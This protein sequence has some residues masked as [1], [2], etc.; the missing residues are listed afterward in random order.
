MDN[1]LV[2]SRYFHGR[3]DSDGWFYPITASLNER[4]AN[5]T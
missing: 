5:Q 1:P 3:L 4:M 2:F